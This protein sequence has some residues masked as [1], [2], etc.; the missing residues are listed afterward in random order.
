MSFSILSV[1]TGNI[2][3]S[4]V[5]ELMLARDLSSV[6]GIHV[7]SAGTGA[8]VGAGVPDPARLRAAS[9]GIDASAHEA[10]QINMAMIR[11]ADLVLTM[12]REHRR[13]V[14]QHVPA[15]MRRSFTLREF[16]RIAEVV[17]PQL[18]DAV[19]AAGAQ[20]AEDAVRAGVALAAALRGTVPPPA[21][22]SDFDVIDPYRRSEDIYEQSFDELRPAAEVVASYLTAAARARKSD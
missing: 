9:I 8:L 21:D 19:R 12:A 7:E 11:R 17:R 1:C 4:P 2:C 14:V 18:E 16:A 15:A 3:R 10:R 5:A 22:P 6:A 20:T 13:V